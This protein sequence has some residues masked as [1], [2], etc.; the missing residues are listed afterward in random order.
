MAG[1]GRGGVYVGSLKGGQAKVN[2]HGSVGPKK[3]WMI[4]SRAYM[5]ISQI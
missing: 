5:P 2:S 4:T 1:K 3:K